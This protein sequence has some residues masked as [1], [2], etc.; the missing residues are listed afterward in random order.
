LDVYDLSYSGAALVRTPRVDPL[1]GDHISVDVH[2]S[3]QPEFSVTGEVVRVTEKI[4][5]I[6]F[7]PM[8]TEAR[9]ALERFL[10]AKMIG[11]HVRPI[12]PKYF[13]RPGSATHWFHG[14]NNTNIFL[15]YEHTKLVRAS[16]EVGSDFLN[17]QN[18]QFTEGQS[19]QFLDYENDD[20]ARPLL[21]AE[22][23]ASAIGLT[24][25]M[26]RILQVLSQVVDPEKVLEP[27]INALLAQQKSQR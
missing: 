26:E 16:V 27:L 5:A 3:G 18:G 13:A 12:D 19:S 6:T 14:P 9:T 20:Y 10:H 21:E 1:Q 22:P 15:W 7:G 25:V 2:L 8:A 23:I 4:V 11:L 17:W 24:P